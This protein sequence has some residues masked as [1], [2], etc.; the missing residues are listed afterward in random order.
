[1]KVVVIGGGASGMVCAIRLARRN[2]NVE[3][4]EKNNSVCKKVL[5]TGNGKCNYFNSD[6]NINH[7]RSNYI[8]FL[9]DIIT[10]ENINKV[11]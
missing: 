11:Q 7:Y 3:I 8:N 2:I 5:V 9:D 1:M 4:L 10:N 6:I